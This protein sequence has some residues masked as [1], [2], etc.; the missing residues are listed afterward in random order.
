MGRSK[1][2]LPLNGKSMLR[3]VI[4]AALQ[5]EVAE[6]LVVLGGHASEL[7]QE[8][9]LHSR[10]KRVLN[11]RYAEGQTT[12]LQAGLLAADPE[13]EAAI[14]LLGDQPLI[15]SAAIDAL[16]GEFR[17]RRPSLV[18]PLYG[19]RRGHPILFARALFPELLALT[20]SQ[21]RREVVRRHSE[22]TSAVELSM[23]APP[24]DVD[25][26]EDYLAV[27]RQLTALPRGEERTPTG[28]TECDRAND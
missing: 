27:T 6:V 19:G 17:K 8:L 26:W 20:P 14:A 15:A 25:T 22:E 21:S 12:S 16:V 24:Q 28:G 5:S 11:Q 2:N 9:P 3:H 13:C 10:V 1:L 18:V 4:D 23:W 7:E